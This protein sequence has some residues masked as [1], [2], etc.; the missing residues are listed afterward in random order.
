MVCG[1]IVVAAVTTHSGSPVM[2]CGQFIV[3]CGVPV[4]VF[5][6]RFVWS[7]VLFVVGYGFHENFLLGLN[8]RLR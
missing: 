4:Q 3:F 7:F 8:E 6:A 1:V 5:K 2:L